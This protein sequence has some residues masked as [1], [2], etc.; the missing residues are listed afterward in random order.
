MTKSKKLKPA[1]EAT[2]IKSDKDIPVSLSQLSINEMVEQEE[3][4][5]M[6]S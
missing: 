4:E 2:N 6:A 1:P 5:E 3:T